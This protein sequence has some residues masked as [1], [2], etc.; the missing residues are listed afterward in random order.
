GGF[1]AFDIGVFDREFQM[2][3]ENVAERDN[4]RVRVLHKHLHHAAPLTS[5]ADYSDANAVIRAEDIRARRGRDADGR[6]ALL[7]EISAF[8][9][10]I[11]NF[12]FH[13]LIWDLLDR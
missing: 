5:W 11:H 6:D 9:S 12:L 13:L 8:D 1:Y 10:V 2:L 4:L 7:D 3:L